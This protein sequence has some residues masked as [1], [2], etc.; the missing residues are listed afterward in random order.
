MANL[1]ISILP[2]VQSSGVKPNDLFVI[3]NYDVPSGTTKNITALDLQ[4]YTTSGITNDIITGA[5]YSGGTLV[6][7]TPGGSISVTGFTNSFSGGTITGA[8]SFTGGLTANTISATTYQNLP[9]SGLTAGSNISLTNNNGNYTISVTGD[10]YWTSGSTGNYSIKVKNDSG[11]DATGNYAIAEGNNTIAIGDNSH[12]EGNTTIAGWKG[13]TVDYI[14]GGLLTLNSSYGDVTSEFTSSIIV[15]QDGIKYGYNTVTF[16][17]TTN[18]EIFLDDTTINGGLNIIADLDNLNSS[19]A[20]NIMGYSSHAEGQYTKAL[21]DKSHAEGEGSMASGDYSHAEGELTLASG[22]SSHAEGWLTIASGGASHAEGYDTLAINGASHAEGEGTR[23]GI[24]GFATYEPSN[25]NL[26]LVMPSSYGDLTTLLI[27]PLLLTDIN[28]GGQ[29]KTIYD[30]DDILGITFSSGTNTEIIFNVSIPSYY[31]VS[32]IVSSLNNPLNGD[33]QSI[34]E[35]SH[36]EGV[37][38]R[39]Y[40]YGA[41]AEGWDTKA[42]GN[43]SHAEG[44]LTIA[45]GHGSHAGGIGTFASGSTS[46]IH[47]LGSTIIG[48]RS[49]VLGGQNITGTTDDTVYVPYLNI[50]SATTNNLIT[51]VLVID[52]NGDV[53]KRNVDTIESTFTGG[54]VSGSTSFT[55]G[56]SA[57]TISATIYQNLPVNGLTAGNNIN[58]SGSSGNFTIS[59]TGITGGASIDPYNNGGSGTTISWDVSGVSTNYFA[60]LIATTT[61]NLTNVRNGDYGTIILTQ[62]SVGGRT[63]NLGTVNGTSATHRVANGGGGS[64]VLTSNPNAIDILTFT[65]NGSVMYWTVGNDYT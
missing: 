40:G 54:T 20:D 48:N 4:D 23:A 39:T 59:V 11:L 49:A 46:F 10:T 44:E 34:G 31:V 64:I 21:G 26:L 30:Y 61:L 42:F 43:S 25:T 9:V 36:A 33:I 53:K 41:H 28:S 5:T 22:K 16:S 27:P 51:E 6:L 57:N 47:S 37:A 63:L 60:T 18:T 35:G 2:N 8:T 14:V 45:L 13:F 19:F 50:Q 55:N 24:N 29:S 7:N 56:L 52:T 65:Y 58:I 15:S 1:P 32:C 3:V 62:D 12:T 17:S 38:T